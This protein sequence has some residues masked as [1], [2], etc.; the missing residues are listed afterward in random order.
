MRAVACPHPIAATLS[1]DG[2]CP[3]CSSTP[4]E[5]GALTGWIAP[6]LSPPPTA[7]GDNTGT[8]ELSTL[9]M[10]EAP[11]GVLEPEPATTDGAARRLT[12]GDVRRRVRREHARRA[13]ASLA[14]FCKYA[15]SSLHASEALIWN[16][17]HDVICEYAQKLA[18]DLL[19]C[20]ADTSRKMI[21]Q[22]IV[23]NVPPRS[24]KTE[25]LG[26]FLPV[27]L[28]LLDPTLKIRYVSGNDRVR[29]AAS[30][31]SRDL[32]ESAWFKDTF[33]IEWAIRQDIDAV[34]LYAN[35]LRGERKSSTYDQRIVG[36]GSDVI[37]NDDPIDAEDAYSEVV[38]KSVNLKWDEAIHNRVN[39]PQRCLRI[40]IMQRL[41]EDDW[42]GHVI[43]SGAWRHV[44]IPMRYESSVNAEGKPTGCTC[45]DCFGPGRDY[46]VSVFGRYDVRRHVGELLQ[47]ERFPDEIVKQ[48]EKRLGSYGAA[49]QLQQRPAPLEGGLFKK[50]WWQYFDP[51]EAPKMDRVIMSVDCS[52]KKTE[53]G[54]RTAML[55]VGERGPHRYIL[56]NVTIPMDIL[57]MRRKLKELLALW[58]MTDNIV[59]EDKS[60][61]TP[62]ITELQLELPCVLPYDPKGNDK[63]SRALSAVPYVE[64]KN[65]LLPKG[66]PWLD[67]FIHELGV[68]PNGS[69]DDQ[70]DAF[71]QAINYLRGENAWGVMTNW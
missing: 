56:D 36:E 34:E 9:V 17:H 5:L 38:R 26:V 67:A 8:F 19:L 60:T 46:R 52:G 15:W 30:R 25:I 40:G 37:I 66:A 23:F 10:A 58:P 45:A 1:T 22:N 21:A 59:I 18:E 33:A 43:A 13:R 69:H 53:E 48:E 61:G 41:H 28:W 4:P 70:V 32:I 7:R 42:T 54:S 27:W 62:L 68:F 55:I 51:S 47:V 49:G 64:A 6:A 39:D 14:Q 20:R 12:I 2:V 50:A 3:L 24:L 63:V 44:V 71:S 31:N 57:D 11:A 29:K 16:W 35:T 65:V